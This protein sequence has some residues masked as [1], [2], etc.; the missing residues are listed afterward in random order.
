MS[1]NHHY[2]GNQ[3]TNQN[4]EQQ[5]Y[6]QTNPNRGGHGK[7]HNYQNKTHKYREKTAY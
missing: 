4:A 2:Q 5:K 6:Y 1:S 7:S 3:S